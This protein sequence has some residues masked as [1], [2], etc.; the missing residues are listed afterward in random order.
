MTAGA[1]YYRNRKEINRESRGL[2]G[3]ESTTDWAF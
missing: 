2:E 1:D 3:R